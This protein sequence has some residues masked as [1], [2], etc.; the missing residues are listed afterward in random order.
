MWFR[1]LLAEGEDSIFV[2]FMGTKLKGDLI[3]N[4][5]VYQELLWGDQHFERVMTL[6]NIC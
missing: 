2:A 3:T 1:Y 4:A 6:E 5:R